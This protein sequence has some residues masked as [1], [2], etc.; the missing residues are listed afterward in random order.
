MEFI[1]NSITCG[2]SMDLSAIPCGKGEWYDQHNAYMSYGP[3]TARA[4]GAQWQLTSVSGIG[5]IHSC[6]DLEITMPQVWDK[7]D[8]REDSVSWDFNRYIPDI[9]TICLG[10]NDGI[11]DS[12]VFCN[13]YSDFVR[14]IRTRY[15][16]AK[17]ILLT[18]PMADPALAA[19]LVNY[20][21]AITKSLRHNGDKE[22][23]RYFFK[24]RY[25]TGCGEHPDLKEHQQISDELVKFIRRIT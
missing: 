2:S 16:H 15:P 7:T 18:S 3:L 17:I 25:H 14:T 23:S 24:K 20:L 10:Q 6:C 1:G 12:A 5:L 4:L 22:V 19:V 8:M 13:A 11:Q 9:V 21:S